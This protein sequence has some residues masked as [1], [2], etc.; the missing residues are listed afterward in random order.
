MPQDIKNT[1]ST[2]LEKTTSKVLKQTKKT[3]DSKN[4]LKTVKQQVKLPGK[5]V[6]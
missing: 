2:N 4:L 6:E 5:L 1:V 3:S